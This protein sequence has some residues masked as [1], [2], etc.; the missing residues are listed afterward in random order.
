MMT[1]FF[2]V[3]SLFFTL[4]ASA[5]ELNDS[6]PASTHEEVV[7][8]ATRT[9]TKAMQAPVPVQV[10]SQ[11]TIRQ[12]GSLRLNEVLQEQSGIFITAGTGSSAVGGGVFG[13]GIQLQG[14]SPDY[15]LILLDGEPLTGRQGGV[16]DL[17]RLAVGNIRKI[18]IV[19]G[20]SSSLYGSEAMGGVV[21]ILTER[22]G[23]NRFSAGARYG[24]FGT[25]DFFASGSHN[26]KKSSW[27]YFLN[28]NSSQGYDLDKQSP[29]KTLDPYHNYTAQLKW[30]YQP[31]DK[32]HIS[33]GGRYYNNYQQSRFAIN[34]IPVNIGG[35]GITQEW[36]LNPVITRRFSRFVKSGLHIA[37]SRYRFNQQLDSLSNKASYY[38]D[39]FVQGF[40]RAENLTV[41]DWSKTHQT[42]L[43]GGYTLHTINTT[44]YREVKRQQIAHAFLQHQWMPANSFTLTAG[45]RY[46]HNNDFA[47]RLSPK[48][49][50]QWKVASQLRFH[51]SYG[52]GFKAPDF[53]QLYL[54]FT[55][56]AA[57][58][59]S[60]Y[61]VTEFSVAAL[62]QQQAQGL[63]AEILPAAYTIGQLK[64][65]VSHGYNAG[66]Q[67]QPTKNLH[68]DVNF[69]RNDIGNLIVFTP[70][71]LQANGS[72]VF[73]YVNVNRAFTQGVE[74]NL[75]YRA[76]NRFNIVTGYQYLQT[77]D[78]KIL[79]DVKAGKVYG[80]DVEGGAARL[81]TRKDYTG[82]LNR[83]SHLLNARIIYDHAEKRWGGSLRATWRSRWGVLDRDANGFA[84]FSNEF[85]PALWQVHATASKSIG[86]VQV[87]A[88]VNNILNA[89]NARYAPNLPG[90]NVFISVNYQLTYK[91]E[92]K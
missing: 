57:N 37:A 25:A 50:L 20:P 49:A 82:L 30:Q 19:K 13:N 78:K 43:G 89:T 68:A 46:D 52:A 42:T 71:A 55:N 72:Q 79:A 58:G 66:A 47:S 61:G 64:P 29:E 32:T 86:A 39:D 38:K 83:S 85:A 88:G 17:S 63:V 3:I 91:K 77:A 26:L 9:E 76:G 54:H 67:W 21:N 62:Q 12:M 31:D 8:T 4:S 1:R 65:E 56:S 35:R 36:N 24:S 28:R 22:P 11:K 33:V 60:I 23:I 92:N 15:T 84:N 75:Q 7:V 53:R 5:Q 6:L 59:Y 81:L 45:L 69:F 41:L 44:R 51:A 2:I 48:L 14:L 74:C 34:S 16:L 40:A 70:V 73:S 87:Q 80:R 27:Y 90:R 10:I 18:E